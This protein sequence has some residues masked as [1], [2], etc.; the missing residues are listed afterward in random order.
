MKKILIVALLL[1]SLAANAGLYKL[2][3]KKI[4][5]NLYRDN[6]SGLF[7]KTKYCYEYA[8][9]WRRGNIAIRTVL[10]R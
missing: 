6:N 1:N 5:D 10:L 3:V 4:A 2:E 7:I 8:L 9:I